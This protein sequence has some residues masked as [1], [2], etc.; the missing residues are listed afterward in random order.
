MQRTQ[1]KNKISRSQP[2]SHP[3]AEPV[4]ILIIRPPQ[5]IEPS[6]PTH[7]KTWKNI[8]NIGSSSPMILSWS[9]S[10]GS[11]HY[12]TSNNITLIDT[13]SLHCVALR[14][15]AYIL[16]C[17]AWCPCACINP[18]L[19]IYQSIC[20]SI[21]PCMHPSIHP[22]HTY[23][24]C[25]MYMRMWHQMLAWYYV[26][27]VVFPFDDNTAPCDMGR[28]YLCVSCKIVAICTDSPLARNGMENQK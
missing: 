20:P 28:K 19:S 9:T 13:I 8:R 25:K 11:L 22:R 24:S 5:K 16:P 2:I 12:I 23:S 15:I 18:H 10:R 1:A 26:C 3:S 17:I 7:Q 14:C 4:E 21:H 6:G 27:S